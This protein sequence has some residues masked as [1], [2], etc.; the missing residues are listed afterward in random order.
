[1]RLAAH[2]SQVVL[3]LAILGVGAGEGV[4]RGAIFFPHL[5]LRTVGALGVSQAVEI[6]ECQR[7]RSSWFCKKYQFY[8]R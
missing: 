2:S 5:V 8:C 7:T 4:K 1:M 3:C 6:Q